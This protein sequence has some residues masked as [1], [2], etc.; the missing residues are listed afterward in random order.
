LINKNNEHKYYLTLQK[1]YGDM[2]R[3]FIVV[4]VLI[5]LVSCNNKNQV[6]KSKSP[7]LDS[8]LI[9]TDV[10]KNPITLK[11]TAL[12]D[13]ELPQITFKQKNFDFGVLIEGEKVAHTFEFENTGNA[14]LVITKVSTTCGCTVAN[15]PKNPIPPG[16]KGKIEVVF[17]SAGKHGYQHKIVRI[18]ANT[19][20]NLTELSIDAQVLG[21]DEI[22]N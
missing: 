20:P 21:P 8:G 22:N 7:D 17:N 9:S 13:K 1:N 19:Q 10:V 3:V 11:D 4:L 2:K 18:L 5:S 12:S 16:G 6:Q 15:Y 14:D